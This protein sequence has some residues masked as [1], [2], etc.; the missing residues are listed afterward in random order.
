MWADDIPV[1]RPYVKPPLPARPMSEAQ[2]VA[3]LGPVSIPMLEPVQLDPLRTGVLEEITRLKAMEEDPQR[4]SL[5][6]ALGSL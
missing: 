2:L 4:I 3:T 5:L 1:G 6:D